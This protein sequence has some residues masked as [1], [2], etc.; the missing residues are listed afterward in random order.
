MPSDLQ[1][2]KVLTFSPLMTLRLQTSFP[3]TCL[4]SYA[5]DRDGFTRRLAAIISSA[6]F[7]FNLFKV[8]VFVLSLLVH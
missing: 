5:Q 1:G 3:L 8:D 4:I 6:Q 7:V 2:S